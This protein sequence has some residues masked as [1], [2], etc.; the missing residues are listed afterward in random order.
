MLTANS[1]L[2][3]P[4]S[5]SSKTPRSSTRARLAP[6]CKRDLAPENFEPLVGK[7]APELRHLGKIDGCETRLHDLPPL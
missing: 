5:I 7:D 3:S 6:R 2:L 4:R 1:I